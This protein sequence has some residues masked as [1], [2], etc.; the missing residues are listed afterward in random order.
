[1]SEKPIP[2]DLWEGEPHGGPQTSG[3]RASKAVIW[4]ISFFPRLL[5][6][7]EV[8]GLVPLVLQHPVP[9]QAQ[10]YR[11]VR[12]QAETQEL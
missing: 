2:K 5:L 12:L 10:N 1:M 9:L 4:A 8:R 11:A 7:P 6:G 3:H